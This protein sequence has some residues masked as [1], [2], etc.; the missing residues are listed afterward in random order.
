M[1]AHHPKVIF[2]KDSFLFLGGEDANGL[3]RF[4]TGRE[5]LSPIAR[6]IW[7]ENT[8]KRLARTPGLV[9][10]IVP[11]A[12]VIY[13]D[14]LPDSFRL[15]DR[16]PA[17]DVLEIAG[18]AF[19]YADALLERLRAEGVT[20]FTGH[21]SHWTEYAA[22]A[23][24]L[25]IR[26]RLGCHEKFETGYA[27]SLQHEEQDLLAKVAPPDDPRLFRRPF[28]RPDAI[29][30]FS[31]HIAKKGGVA[32]FYNPKAPPR[33]LMAFMTSFGLRLT[34]FLGADFRE[35][36]AV[37]GTA[38]DWRLWSQWRP[39]CV[40]MEMPERFLHWPAI[41]SEAPTTLIA[42]LGR[43]ER[44]DA[45]GPFFT[46]GRDLSFLSPESQALAEAFTAMERWLDSGENGVGASAAAT[47]AAHGLDGHGLDFARILRQTPNLFRLATGM[48]RTDVALYSAFDQVDRRILRAE[49]L[50]FI[51]DGEMGSLVRIRI[52]LRENRPADARSELVTH[53]ARF[54]FSHE[55]L[56][57]AKYLD[58]APLA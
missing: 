30:V 51:P 57:F 27:L 45:A 29:L 16:R 11:E 3:D 22:R 42:M 41:D 52:I 50:P 44:R 37:Y 31:S 32:L 49:H 2:G 55:S 4:L 15:S 17:H 18:D 5:T 7:Q 36:I 24:W 9:G 28:S 58:V 34:P 39:D 26:G 8:E 10:L 35:V 46:M 12:H 47:L 14:K 56:W 1:M 43:A 23:A 19:F 6:R 33:R 53:I 21:D 54:G 20:V 38:V 25:K 40:L 48:H 13:R